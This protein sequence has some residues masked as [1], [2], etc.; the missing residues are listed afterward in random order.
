METEV[1]TFYVVASVLVISLWVVGG[2]I[3]YNWLKVKGSLDP[4]GAFPEE[5][6]VFIAFTWPLWV[7][8]VLLKCA[9]KMLIVELKRRK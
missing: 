7:I 5:F 9:L 1:D 2:V 8:P 3:A 4:E 6:G